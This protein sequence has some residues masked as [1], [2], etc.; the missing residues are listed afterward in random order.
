MEV[1][2]ILVIKL[3]SPRFPDRV[4]LPLSDLALGLPLRLLSLSRGESHFRPLHNADHRLP[5]PSH[6]AHTSTFV[7]LV[8]AAQASLVSFDFFVCLFC[9]FRATQ[10]GVGGI[11][12]FPG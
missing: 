12:K 7:P 9:F 8:Q 5:G 6:A 10:G 2:G 4:A 11:W 1:N 3:P